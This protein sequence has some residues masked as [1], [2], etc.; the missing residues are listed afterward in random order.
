MEDFNDIMAK[1]DPT[2]NTSKNILTKYEKVKI[3]SNRAE[4]I[5]RNA[6]IYVDVDRINMS[7]REI[8]IKELEERKLPFMICRKL[9]N[10]QK[11]YFRLDDLIIS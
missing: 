3:I 10:G 9:A 5:Q 1:Y 4:Q 2:K 7:A 8:A 11:E 6:P